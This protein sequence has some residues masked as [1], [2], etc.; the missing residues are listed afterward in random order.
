MKLNK[1]QEKIIQERLQSQMKMMCQKHGEELDRYKT[2]IS[3]L[4]TQLWSVGEKL[5]SEQQ[6]KDEALKRLKERNC[7]YTEIETDQPITISRK[8]C[9]Y[10]RARGKKIARR[11][12]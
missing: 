6:R 3:E 12:R 4:S 1:E 8:T 11:E 9:K 2:H 7:Q 10:V 5:L